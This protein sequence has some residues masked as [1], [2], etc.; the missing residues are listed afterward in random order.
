MYLTFVIDVFVRRILGW[1]V[2]GSICT[3]FGLDALE[4]ALYARQPDSP[5]AR[6]PDSPTARQ[7]GHCVSIRYTARLDEAGIE[8]CVGSKGD[9][10][11]GA[12][13]ETTNGLYKGG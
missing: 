2:S 8:P 5:T 1:R 13:T 7:R 10:Y 3:D 6:Q 9:S 11:D 12:L 4:Q